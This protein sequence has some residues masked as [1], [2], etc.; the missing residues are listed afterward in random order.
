[1][2]V[3]LCDSIV[4]MDK[5]QLEKLGAVVLPFPYAVNN[6]NKKY[7]MKSN[8]DYKEFYNQTVN[9]NVYV[10]SQNITDYIEQFEPFLKKGEDI[11]YMSYS[12]RLNPSFNNLKNALTYL[13]NEYPD[14]NIYFV[15]TLS[16]STGAGIIIYEALKLH[17]N[18]ASDEDVVRYVKN[19]RNNFSAFCAISDTSKIANASFVEGATQ[20]KE[21]KMLS[22]KPIITINQGKVEIVSKPIGMKKALRILV[23]KLKLLGQNV[24]DYKVYIMHSDYEEGANLLCEKVR[25]YLG[26][27]ADIEIRQIGPIV[28]MYCKKGAVG[29]V[30]HSKA[31]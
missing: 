18:G 29:I 22:I 7:E 23:N 30:F 20:L 17:N 31:K 11:I 27:E 3:I 21:G 2:S 24:N 12:I 16:V 14:R 10:Q 13:K 15:D 25:E 1:M 4:D 8:F 9:Q 6:E 26:Y 5:K 28:G 19:N